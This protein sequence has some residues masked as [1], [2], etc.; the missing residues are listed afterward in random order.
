VWKIAA[1]LAVAVTTAETQHLRLSASAGAEQVR[2]GGRVTLTLE[3]ALKPGMH[4]YAPAVDGYI[5]ITW[6][7]APNEAIV[8]HAVVTPPAQ[9]LRLEALDETLPVYSGSFRLSRDIT[10]SKSAKGPLTLGG[11][12]RYQACDDRMCYLPKTVP[13]KWTLDVQ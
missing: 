12:F 13:L 2:A 4:V 5:P 6:S 9:M 1:F 8:A 11:T 3:I 7:M 10:V